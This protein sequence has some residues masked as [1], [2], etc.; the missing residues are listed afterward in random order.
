MPDIYP[1]SLVATIKQSR[2]ELVSH[3]LQGGIPI[4][5]EVP[6]SVDPRPALIEGIGE[7]MLASSFI[8]SS[9]DPKGWCVY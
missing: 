3:C 8:L 5:E 6:P 4:P 1:F 2:P 7:P 9:V